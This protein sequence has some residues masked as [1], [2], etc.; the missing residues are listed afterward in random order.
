MRAGLTKRRLTLREVSCSRIRSSSSMMT[1]AGPAELRATECRYPTMSLKELCSLPIRE[2]VHPRGAHLW[3]W[4]TWPKIRDGWHVH[5]MQAWGFEWQGQIVWD[6]ARMGL[7][8]Y[9]RNQTEVLLLGV[10]KRMPL[11]ARDQRDIVHAPRT[12]LHSEKPEVFRRIVERLSPGPRLAE[13]GSRACTAACTNWEDRDTTLEALACALSMPRTRGIRNPLTLPPSS[14][15]SIG[16]AI[17]TCPFEAV[18]SSGGSTS[19]A[20]SFA[21]FGFQPLGYPGSAGMRRVVQRTVHGA[22]RP[23]AQAPPAVTR[24]L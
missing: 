21:V 13:A 12:R 17:D 18:G 11:L 4:C 9:L 16:Q 24:R 10:R 15:R 20:L 19:I 5:V 23:V 3:L 14:R 7:G 8:R 22:C 6:K 2:L 1:G